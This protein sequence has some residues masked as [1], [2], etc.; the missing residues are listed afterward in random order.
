[1]ISNA[2]SKRLQKARAMVGY[3]QEH[4]EP[5]S[6]ARWEAEVERLVEQLAREAKRLRA[7][8]KLNATSRPAK[9]CTAAAE[10][11]EAQF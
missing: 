1:M 11:L 8:A 10:K 2:T 6:V 3:W 5:Q 7:Y 4:N 9:F